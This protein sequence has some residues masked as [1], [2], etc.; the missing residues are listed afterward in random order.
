LED[1]QLLHCLI[2]VVDLKGKEESEMRLFRKKRLQLER[3]TG[4]GSL[5]NGVYFFP[6]KNPRRFSSG[7]VEAFEQIDD[8]FKELDV[9]TRYFLATEVEAETLVAD[10]SEY[11][12]TKA[13]LDTGKIKAYF[14]LRP[15]RKLRK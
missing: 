2:I 9:K 6:I 4:L 3:R 7:E 1:G 8:L 12:A 5:K 15:I 11:N 13:P 10:L 14:V